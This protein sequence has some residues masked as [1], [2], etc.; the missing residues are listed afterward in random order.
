M[1]PGSPATNANL[2]RAEKEYPFRPSVKELSFHQLDR[3]RVDTLISNLPIGLK[4]SPETTEV[5]IHNRRATPYVLLHSTLL[6]CKMALHREYLPTT[7]EPK[8]YPRGPTDGPNWE[9]L[10]KA[11]ECE[12]PDF[13]KNSART[14]FKATRDAFD[15]FIACKERGALVESPLITFVCYTVTFNSTSLWFVSCSD[16][17]TLMIV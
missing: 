13:F 5:H 11:C 2:R 4:L 14:F 9:A 12:E 3:K 10:Q 16:T 15:L 17:E 7:P 8:S 6:M 1:K